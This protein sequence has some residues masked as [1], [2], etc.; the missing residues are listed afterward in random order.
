MEPANNLRVIVSL[1]KGGSTALIHSL[2]HAPGVT[3][4][5]QT[6]KSGQRSRGEPDYGIYCQ[7]HEGV[8]LS[9]ETI[10][11]ST[12][13]D[14]T[15]RVFPSDAALRAT[16]PVFLFRDPVDTRAAWARAGW[17]SPELFT[18]AY[19]HAL[20][21]YERA[22]QLTPRAVAVRY[23]SFGEDAEAALRRLCAELGIEFNREMLHWRHRFPDESPVIWREDVQRD[24]D[25]GQ[26]DSARAATGFAYRR[27]EHRLPDE[28]VEVI[29]RLFRARYEALPA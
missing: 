26:S 29:E 24:F 13:A 4:Y 18:L 25:R 5:L 14:C 10:G 27:C 1:C 2:A 12:V 8:V 20:A 11:H 6:V 21:L 9:K 15:L 17:G 16:A 23:A 22:R 28:E 19:G 3:C 7:R